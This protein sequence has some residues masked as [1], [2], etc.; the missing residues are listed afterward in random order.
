MRRSIRTEITIAGAPRDVWDV[1]VDLDRY[2]EWNPSSS[3][4]RGFPLMAN[5]S[6]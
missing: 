4:L 3:T 1:L 5:G 2:G 6:R